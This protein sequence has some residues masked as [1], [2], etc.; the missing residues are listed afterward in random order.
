MGA[1]GRHRP[2]RSSHSRWSCSFSFL[3]S[4]NAH[5]SA[6]LTSRWAVRSLTCPPKRRMNPVSREEAGAGKA[7]PGLAPRTRAPIPL[8][9]SKP[10][11]H[12]NAPVLGQNRQKPA[13]LAARHPPPRRAGCAHNAYGR[14]PI[15]LHPCSDNTRRPGKKPN[16]YQ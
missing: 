4:P 16:S 15:L 7:G 3:P 12:S 9:P 14:R 10:L 2:V 1:K 5:C 6:L 13:K 8:A 11:S